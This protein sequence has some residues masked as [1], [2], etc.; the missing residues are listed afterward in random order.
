MKTD[1]FQ[2]CSHCYVFHICWNTEHNTFTASS[3]RICNSSLGIPSPPPALFVVMLPKAHLT[4][5]SRMFGS[6]W[7][8]TSLWLSGSWRSSL[9]SSS[10]YSCHLFLI[11]SASVRSIPFLKPITFL[12]YIINPTNSLKIFYEKG[13]CRESLLSAGGWKKSRNHRHNVGIAMTEYVV[14]TQTRGEKN[15]MVRSGKLSWGNIWD[16]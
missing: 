16:F 7:V 5:H 12:S 2:S 11:S 6:R 4:L 15:Q 3:F 9:Y 13:Q 8:I 14:D 1:L 10:V